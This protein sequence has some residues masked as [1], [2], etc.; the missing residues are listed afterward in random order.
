MAK[1]YLTAL[2]IE[3]PGRVFENLPSAELVEHAV[4]GGRGHLASNG[5]ITV[6]TGIY[7]GRS[8]Q[9]KYVVRSEGTE[10]VVW[11]GPN[12]PISPENARVIQD[13]MAEHLDGQDLFVV[14][15]SAGADPEYAIPVRVITPFAWQALFVRNM[16]R[17]EH[18]EGREDECLTV[19]V[20]PTLQAPAEELGLRTG[21]A[22]VLD[23]ERRLILVCGSEYAGEIKKSVFSVMNYLM[24]Q[25]G[26]FPMHCSANVG[27]D[28]KVA[29]FFGLSGTGKTSLS[30]DP[31]RRLIGDDE[32]VW[33]ENSTFNIEGGCYAKMI[34]LSP[35]KEPEIWNA[36]RFGSVLENVVLDENRVPDYDDGSRTENT[37]GCYPLEFIPNAVESGMADAPSAVVFLTADAFGVL[38]PISILTPEQAMY[39][40]L[41]GYTAKLAGTE[42]GV[43]EPEPNFSACFGQPFLPL[44]PARYAEL[45]GERLR[46]TGVPV[47]LINTGWSGGPYGVG[48]RISIKHT[49][50]MVHAA[51]N[52][53]L[54]NTPTTT[55][56]IF[57]L[58]M[59]TE[60]PGVPSDILNPRNTWA[61]KD[62]YDRQAHDLA[63]QFEENYR[64][65]KGVS[66][67]RE[68]VAV[69]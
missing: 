53:V 1:S 37:R 36:I 20:A 46:A 69:R 62:A 38:P 6:D 32:H 4:C 28:G 42:R 47:Y 54:A 14:D 23:L 7:T 60:V 26:V 49:R 40:F 12:K 21:T 5:A 45:F 66:S 24:P 57:G 22:M 65:F 52:G 34:K 8:P 11:W 67:V 59:P 31:K 63:A 25:R 13:L 39:H 29:L 43:T 55:D 68:A 50:A 33:T 18:I 19:L 61:D 15:A 10:D 27:E 16:F 58:T 9:D 30:A 44:P 51:L 41:N 3:Q 56:P 48:E 64:K 2:G 35:E 17:R